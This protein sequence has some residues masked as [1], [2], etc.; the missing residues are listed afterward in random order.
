MSPKMDDAGRHIETFRN[1]AEELLADIEIAVL[2][3]EQRPEDRKSIDRLFRSMHTIK[4]SGAMFG[5]NEIAEFTHHVE[6]VLDKVRD[7]V[8]PVTGNLINLILACRDWI[9]SKISFPE[10]PDDEENKDIKNQLI[11]ALKDLVPNDAP[12]EEPV[13]ESSSEKKKGHT[14]TKAETTYWI[15]FKPNS[16]IM[17][18]GMDPMPILDELRSMGDCYLTSITE[19][20]PFLKELN[21]EDCY[22]YWDINLTTRKSR[23]DVRD[24][25]VFVEDDSHITIKQLGEPVY[26]DTEE[27]IPRIGEILIERGDITNETIIQTIGKQQRIGE[28]L[29]NSGVISSD[30]IKSALSEQKSIEKRK[31]AESSKNIRVASEKLDTLINLVGELVITQARLT[32]LSEELNELK[33][34]DT[35][36][37]FER[38]TDRLRVCALNMRMLPIGTIFGKFRRLVRDLSADLGKEIELV[39]EGAETELDK[40][41]IER[42]NDPLVHLIRNSVDHGIETPENR[43]RKGKPKKGTILLKAAHKGADV[44]VTVEDDGVGIDPQVIKRKAIEK[45]LIPENAGLPDKKLLSLIFT[46]GFSTTEKITDVSGR[47]VGMDVVKKEIDALGGAIQINGKADE[48]LII[49]LFLPLTLAIIDGLLVKVGSENFVLPLSHLDE[50]VEL[51]KDIVK[52]RHERCFISVRGE[53]TPYVRLRDMFEI[54]GTLDAIAIEHVVIVNVDGSRIGIVVDEIIGHIQAVIKSLDK[55]LRNIEGISGATIMGDGNVALITDIP[56]IV[57]WAREEEEQLSRSR[58]FENTKNKR[59]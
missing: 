28:I 37:Q 50:C 36:E 11:A 5:F 21:P 29:V 52:S 14:E 13:R 38:L 54:S 12:A 53:L 33:L 26:D 34:T 20:V 30:K 8:I 47:G 35:S 51:T 55:N 1:E 10:N 19:E 22:L 27:V 9:K 32:Q 7:G 18:K 42:L 3:I 39:T 56:G 17:K 2:D 58:R 15:R 46:P 23:G 41:V 25:F 59:S 31:F 44:V 43:I 48:N 4:G 49:N 40:T 6:T 57:R 45:G 16:G 24:V